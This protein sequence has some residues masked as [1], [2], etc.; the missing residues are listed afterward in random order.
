[1]SDVNL[2]FIVNNNSINFTVV[3]ND[4]TIT[5]TDIQLAFYNGGLG[6]PAGST[7]QLQYNNGGVLGGVSN[8]SFSGGNLTLGN[9][10][11]IKI[12]GGSSNAILTTDGTGNLTWGS[13]A[14]NANHANISDVANSVAGANVSGI[15]A[16][17]NYASYAGNVVNANQPNITTVGTLTNVTT[18]GNLTVS[19]NVT[20]NGSSNISNLSSNGN[21]NFA[22][23]GNVTLGTSSNV[24]L[25]GGTN[26]YF[27]QTDGTGNLTW[28]AGTGGGGNGSPGG[29]NTQIQFNDA[30]VFGGNA[31]FTFNKTSGLV[32]LPN[33]LYVSNG[34]TAA[35]YSG[36]VTLPYGIEN[37]FLTTSYTGT[38]DFYIIAGA[39]KYTTDNA[40][41]NITLNFKGNLTTTINTL[42]G[43][44]QS[45]T[46]TYVAKT[47][48]TPYGVI[49]IQIDSVAQSIKWASNVVPAQVANTQTSYVFTIVKTSTTPTYDVLASATRYG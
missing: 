19:G 5:P 45:V 46:A 37:V 10:A 28:A 15:V 2:D 39:I 31:S 13:S 44:G 24:K 23:S 9:V 18:T 16:N 21:V 11:N 17:A 33:N 36:P 6:V 41:G 30:G 34:I 25:T 20:V 8:T 43:N 49:G 12:T 29:A 7:G 22:N 27:L 38:I 40:S 35:K 14:A 3:P 1:M 47:G 42:L 48:S 32:T 26:G 4:I